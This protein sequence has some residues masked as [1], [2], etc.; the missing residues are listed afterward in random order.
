MSVAV[1]FVADVHIANHARLGGPR[2]RGL[3][4]RAVQTLGVLDRVRESA[5]EE[6]AD[7][8]VVGDLF[9]TTRPSPPLVQG[10]R[11]AL[12]G[13]PPDTTQHPVKCY[14]IVGN[15]D[16]VSTEPGHHALASMAPIPGVTYPRGPVVV[17]ESLSVWRHNS[18]IALSM[19][20]FNSKVDGKD[21]VAQCMGSK[22]GSPL[23]PTIACFHLGVEDDDTP[24]WL[25]GQSDSVRLD[26]VLEVATAESVEGVV[27]GNWHGHRHWSSDM[28]EVWQCGA[29]VPTGWGNPSKASEMGT[30]ADPYG[31]VVKWDGR[32]EKGDQ[33]STYVIPGP[34]FVSVTSLAEAM[35]AVEIAKDRKCDLYLRIQVD[36]GDIPQV[37]QSIS[38]MDGYGVDWWAETIP[39][40]TMGSAVR[41]GIALDP[42]LDISSAV[43]EYVGTMDLGDVDPEKVCRRVSEA[44]QRAR[45]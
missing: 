14:T 12:L 34:R 24:P 4:R 29:L 13:T 42:S 45:G 22:K 21:Y 32:R 11:R 41:D 9:D 3:N 7:L 43:K 27:V 6:G 19:Y 31:H 40:D 2:I 28:T 16:Q 33:W 17:E 20:P 39:S 1:H 30:D 10:A 23:L 36:T 44:I 35:V 26:R 15:H 5:D 8:V 38:G 25:R 18:T 37:S